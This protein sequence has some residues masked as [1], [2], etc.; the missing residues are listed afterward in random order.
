MNRFNE[1]V[2][3]LK[4]ESLL[5][6][7]IIAP[8]EKSIDYDL[9]KL[10]L[11]QEFSDS[12]NDSVLSFTNDSDQKLPDF[13]FLQFA[14]EE[15]ITE[16]QIKNVLPTNVIQ[17]SP[18]SIHSTK[19]LIKYKANSKRRTALKSYKQSKRHCKACAINLSSL[20]IRCPYC[21]ERVISTFSYIALIFTSS[22]LFTILVWVVLSL[23]AGG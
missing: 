3:E 13:E 19:K 12:Q 8:M 10:N 18:I 20:S 9:S 7:V 21:H 2:D 4:Q 17:E 1:L 6:Q 22:L 5:D 14:N 15:T 16:N 23:R 11:D